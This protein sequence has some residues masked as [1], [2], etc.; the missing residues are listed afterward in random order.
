[1]VEQ[2]VAANCWGLLVG[3]TTAPSLQLLLLPLQQQLD[4]THSSSSNSSR[5][6]LSLLLLVSARGLWPWLPVATSTHRW[7][8]PRL[9]LLLPPQALACY[10]PHLL[11][12][13]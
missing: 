7:Q 1:M 8:Q 9:P 5:A 2:A 3:S 11:A 6:C 12:V 10:S 4:T 13:A